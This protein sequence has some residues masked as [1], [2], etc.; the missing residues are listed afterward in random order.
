[1]ELLEGNYATHM[2]LTTTHG[3]AGYIT[4]FRDLWVLSI[5]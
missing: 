2:S 3:N 4:Y 5:C 1:M